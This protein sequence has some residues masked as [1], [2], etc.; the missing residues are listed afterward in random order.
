M[1]RKMLAVF[2][3]SASATAVALSASDADAKWRRFNG[4][5]CT[6]EGTLWYNLTG[7]VNYGN[8]NQWATCDIGDDSY[9][10]KTEMEGINVHVYDGHNGDSVRAR[11]CTTTWSGWYGSCGTSSYSGNSYLGNATLQPSVSPMSSVGNFGMLNVELPGS[12]ALK[13]FYTHD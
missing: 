11:L 6:T 9:F 2:L 13:G 10:A 4:T 1:K 5:S 12:S 8:Q 7:L 3:M